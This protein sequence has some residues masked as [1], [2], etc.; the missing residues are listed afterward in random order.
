MY[1]INIYF[2]EISME[3]KMKT[4]NQNSSTFN[5]SIVNINGKIFKGKQV[6]IVNNKLYVM[7]KL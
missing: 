3:G 2:K 5:E 6:S 4:F 7:M 1:T